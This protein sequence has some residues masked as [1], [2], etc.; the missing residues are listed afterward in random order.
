MTRAFGIMAVTVLCFAGLAF[1]GFGQTAPEHRLELRVVNGQSKFFD[2]QTGREFVPRGYNYARLEKLKK[3]SDGNTIPYH[4]T[5]NRGLYDKARAQKALKAMAAG[6]YNTVR[7]FL[8]YNTVG[9]IG[10]PGKPLNTDYIGNFVDFL[11]MAKEYKILVLPTIDWL[12]I[13][14][15]K[16]AE[17]SVWCPDFQCT[18]AHVLSDQGVKANR[19][20]FIAF[21]RA[22]KKAKAPFGALFGYALRNELAFEV[23]LPPLSLTAGSIKTANGKTYALG[24]PKQ[25]QA[26]LD[27]GLVFWVNE[28]RKAIRTEDPTALVGVGLIPPRRPTNSAP[29]MPGTASP[30][31]SSKHRIWI[32]SMSISIPKPTAWA[33]RSL[34]R[35]SA[36]RRLPGRRS[37]WGNSVAC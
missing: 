28:M 34:P 23:D 17:R 9:G 14:D 35:T 5:F 1:Q 12:P 30:N 36:S 3:H 20:F 33:S 37:S 13:A 31:P 26:M 11:R 6:G 32:S 21:A 10:D 24:D 7:V 4:S 18:A 22:L 8:N 2:K 27:E 16:G 15:T 25:K 19:E 29:A